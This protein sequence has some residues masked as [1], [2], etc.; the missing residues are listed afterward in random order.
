MLRGAV[1]R[2]GTLTRTTTGGPAAAA[3]CHAYLRRKSFCCGPCLF[4]DP[5]RMTAGLCS[6]A[7]AG[8]RTEAAAAAAAFDLRSQAARR[9][10]PRRRKREQRSLHNKSAATETG[11]EAAARR[12]GFLQ[13]R[14]SLSNI[15]GNDEG[16]GFRLSDVTPTVSSDPTYNPTI[17][18]SSYALTYD[19]IYDPNYLPV[20]VVKEQDPRHNGVIY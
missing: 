17:N 8:R 19:L 10:P 12:D 3:E 1:R 15:C 13:L 6:S 18:F 4:H 7:A 20:N 14:R 11:A 2:E 5:A 9:N 16:F